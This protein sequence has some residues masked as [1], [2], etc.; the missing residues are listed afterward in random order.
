MTTATDALDLRC[1]SARD[2][3]TLISAARGIGARDPLGL[4]ADRV[5][6]VVNEG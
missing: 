3:L 1:W 4:V 5:L 6:D 2:L